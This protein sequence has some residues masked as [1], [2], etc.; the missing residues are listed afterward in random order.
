MS[1]PWMLVVFIKAVAINLIQDLQNKSKIRDVLQMF[2]D[3][4]TSITN[5]N[6]VARTELSYTTWK[7]LAS[8]PCTCSCSLL[9]DLW[10]TRQQIRCWHKVSNKGHFDKIMSEAQYGI[11]KS[12]FR[13]LKTTRQKGDVTAFLQP[14]SLGIFL[15][16][17]ASIEG[18]C[19]EAWFETHV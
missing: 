1:L 16:E 19:C 4:A 8:W 6:V 11:G 2:A 18:N 3:V 14:D 15:S 17:K 10:D 9:T 5:G 7:S 13:L 12:R